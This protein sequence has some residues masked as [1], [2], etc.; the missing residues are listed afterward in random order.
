MSCSKGTFID[1]VNSIDIVVYENVS[2][3]VCVCV[4][5]GVCVSGGCMC[6]CVCMSMCGCVCVCPYMALCDVCLYV[7]RLTA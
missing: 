4:C 6:G 5:V 7:P 1:L 2:S 3:C